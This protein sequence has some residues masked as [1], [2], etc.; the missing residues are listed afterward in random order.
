[1]APIVA[2][3]LVAGGASLLGSLASS[4]FGNKAAQSAAN[5][6][7]DAINN[8]IAEARQAYKDVSPYFQPYYDT[9]ASALSE[10]KSYDPTTQ[11][12]D[13]A[14]GKSV[15]DFL[16]PAMAYEQQQ[17]QRALEASAA[18]K[19]G[20]YSG[21]AMKALQDRAQQIGRTGWEAAYNRMNQDKTFAY[22]QFTDKFKAAQ[23][24]NAA[25][26]QQLQSL[27]SSGFNAAQA[28]GNLRTGQSSQLQQA[29]G[30]LGNVN[31]Q[32]ASMG[33][34]MK[35][36]ALGNIFSPS[37]AFGALNAYNQYNTSQAQSDYYKSLTNPS[38]TTPQVQPGNF[39][40]AY[41]NHADLA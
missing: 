32:S 26:L 16:N 39:D 22:G 23:A 14:Y 2:G 4:Y 29:F 1:M 21:A 34:W 9:G 12:G 37:N 30:Q 28:L 41:L 13:F 3:A 15:D 38:T 33:D 40:S 25:K 10:L 11:F 27:A 6:Q 7:R 24:N 8:Q 31:A 19:G 18:A 35:S 20:L 5:A 36:Q 17:A